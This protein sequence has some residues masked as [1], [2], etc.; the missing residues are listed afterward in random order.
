MD[1]QHPQHE[2]QDPLNG[3]LLLGEG[4]G[5]AWV[6]GCA[7]RP[8]EW[9]HCQLKALLTLPSAARHGA[10]T[11][12]KRGREEEEGERRKKARWEGEERREPAEEE[13]GATPADQKVGGRG[14]GAWRRVGVFAGHVYDWRWW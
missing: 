6:V 3:E 2:S 9:R 1:G 13:E 8:S 4:V 10:P 14:G 7:R 5:W 12:R 11:A